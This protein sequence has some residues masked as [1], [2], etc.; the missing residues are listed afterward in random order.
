MYIPPYV[1]QGGSA[2]I[3]TLGLT[4]MYRLNPNQ[5]Q[6]IVIDHHDDLRPNSGALR[7]ELP[8]E[9]NL[10]CFDMQLEDSFRL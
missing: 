9:A 5:L 10:Y 8:H 2:S 6:V 4:R 7:E 1:E 3:P